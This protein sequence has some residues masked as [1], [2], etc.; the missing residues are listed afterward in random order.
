MPEGAPDCPA[1]P[2]GPHQCGPASSGFL[3]LLRTN[4]RHPSGTRFRLGPAPSLGNREDV[5]LRKSQLPESQSSRVHKGSPR[6]P[7]TT[8]EGSDA[9]PEPGRPSLTPLGHAHHL[10]AVPPPATSPNGAPAWPADNSL[11]VPSRHHTLRIRPP[12][13]WSRHDLHPGQVPL[14]GDQ[15]GLQKRSSLELAIRTWKRPS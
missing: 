13:G 10:V 6:S 15:A 5:N 8:R 4:P 3:F 7:H 1:S 11:C 2:P 12:R 9:P 14:R